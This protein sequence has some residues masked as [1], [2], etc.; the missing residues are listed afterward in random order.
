MPTRRPGRRGKFPPILALSALALALTLAN[1]IAAG[2]IVGG[3]YALFT[4][5]FN[6]TDNAFTTDTLNAPTSLSASPSGSDIRLDWTATVDTYATGY[7]VLRSMT[8]GSG[9][10]EIDTVTPYTIITYPDNTVSGGIT[11]YYVL[12]SYYQNWTSANSNEASA[13]AGNAVSFVSSADSY[14]RQDASGTNYGDDVLM[15]VGSMKDGGTY[16]NRRSFVKFDVSSIPASSTVGSASLTL[17]ATAVPVAIRTYEVHAVSADWVETIITWSNQPA[18]AAS[19]TDS[20][21]TPASVGCMTWDVA[22][23][24]QAWVDGTTNYG[25]R[26]VDSAE[27]HPGDYLSQF[28]TRENSVTAERPTLDVTYTPP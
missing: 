25:W 7:K 19:A 9:Y 28:R 6:N 12:Q 23:D 27:G 3:A 16:K 4:S 22:S 14:V 26:V 18:V 2:A 24:V 10:S 17:C 15:D 5:V 13:M 1:L 20:A 21:T 11:Y 8:Q